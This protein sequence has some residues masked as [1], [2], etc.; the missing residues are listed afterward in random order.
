MKGEVK[1]LVASEKECCTFLEFKFIGARDEKE[2]GGF[3]L[4]ITSPEGAPQ[5]ESEIL[6]K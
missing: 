3:W 5:L 4:E 6:L 2:E 1:Q